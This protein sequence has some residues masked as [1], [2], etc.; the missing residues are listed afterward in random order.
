MAGATVAGATVAGCA[1]IPDV[2]VYGVNGLMWYILS[3]Y[4]FVLNYQ[5]NF[6]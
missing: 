1:G 3:I 4:L 2:N 5:V 6:L